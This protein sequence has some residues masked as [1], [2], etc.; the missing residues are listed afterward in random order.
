MPHSSRRFRRPEPTLALALAQRW[1]RI[2]AWGSTATS[3]L[4][5]GA[6]GGRDGRLEYKHSSARLSCPSSMFANGGSAMTASHGTSVGAGVGLRRSYGRN[7]I[8]KEKRSSFSSS[9]TARDGTHSSRGRSNCAMRP[10]RDS[11]VAPSKKYCSY[12]WSSSTPRNVAGGR[13]VAA[14]AGGGGGVPGGCR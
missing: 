7:P 6:H 10:Q 3:T 5:R 8:R 14:P 12:A 4:G 2:P 9:T 1:V 13:L 11:R